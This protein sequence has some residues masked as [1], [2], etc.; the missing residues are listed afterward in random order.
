MINP[1]S[2][3][4]NQ[5]LFT[6]YNSKPRS[7]LN[8]DVFL[9]GKLNQLKT[10][11]FEIRVSKFFG[12][13][14]EKGLKIWAV[15]GCVV[16]CLNFIIWD[17]TS[18]WI[19]KDLIILILYANN[20]PFILGLPSK[21]DGEIVLTLFGLIVCVLLLLGLYC[22][23]NILIPYFRLFNLTVSSCSTIPV[24]L[25]ILKSFNFW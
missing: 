11:M 9:R 13:N 5:T 1:E 4:L 24:S 19:G 14:L 17:E 8:Y 6:H 21:M 7:K 15:L 2:T 16:S 12:I 3:W 25:Y 20:F 10:K 18:G 22:V 23:N